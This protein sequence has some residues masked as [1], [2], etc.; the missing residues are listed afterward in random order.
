MA[1]RG[2]RHGPHRDR[3][4]AQRAPTPIELDIEDL[5]LPDAVATTAY[6]VVSEAVVNALR[7]AEAT[8]VR[9]TV[10]A[11]DRDVRVRVDDDG[12]G[13]ART[14][15]A[16]GLEGLG[17]RVAAIG[18]RFEVVSSPGG[19]TRVEALLPCG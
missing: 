18:G 3:T 9:V 10:R 5:E 16:G 4:R 11:D 15:H 1:A 14:R 2:G 7:H 19:G 8:R 12:R 13:G 6:F 17:D